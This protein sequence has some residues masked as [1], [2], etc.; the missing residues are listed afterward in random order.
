LQLSAGW[1]AK[2]TAPDESTRETALSDCDDA[3]HEVYSYLDQEVNWYRSWMIRRHLKGCPPC[4][5]AYKFEQRLRIVVKERLHEDIPP[6][7]MER[8]RQAIQNG[9]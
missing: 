5:Q 9:P 2:E 7:F 6:E 1:S 4:V 8:L 3:L